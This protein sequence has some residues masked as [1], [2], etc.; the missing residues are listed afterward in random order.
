MRIQGRC[1]PYARTKSKYGTLLRNST[2][3]RKIQH[4]YENLTA[5]EIDETTGC[6]VCSED[7]ATIDLPP[8]PAFSACSK[9]APQI[10]SFMSH[11]IRKGAAIQTIVGYHVIKSH[12]PVNGNGDR[13]GFSNHS[14]GTAIDINPEQN[15]LYDNCLAFGPECRLA[16]GGERKPSWPGSLNRPVS[17]G[18]MRSQVSRRICCIFRCP[19]INE[20]LG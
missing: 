13:T 18:A 2:N 4:A 19:D 8:L 10:R 14:Y 15:G 7:Q 6:T 5:S 11:L 16:R 1:L 20:V 17:N 3:T 12:G 9:L